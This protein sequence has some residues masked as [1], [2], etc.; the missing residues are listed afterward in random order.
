MGSCSSA[1]W[2]LFSNDH[3]ESRLV[4]RRMDMSRLAM[5][6]DNVFEYMSPS[7]VNLS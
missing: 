5:N 7:V 1:H 2:D 3:K 6:P 4:Q